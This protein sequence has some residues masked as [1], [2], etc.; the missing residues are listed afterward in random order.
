MSQVR[1]VTDSSCDLPTDV[2]EKLGIS[3]VPLKIRFGAT[4]YTDREDFTPTEFWQMCKESDE[5]PSTAAPSPGAF[6]KVFED[7]ADDGATGIVCLT[8]SAGLSATIEAAKVAKEAVSDRVDVRVIDSRSITVGLGSMAM[9][10]AESAADGADLATVSALGEDLVGRTQVWGALNTLEHLKKGGRIGAAQATLG[11][12]LSIKPIIEIRDG[13]VESPGKQRTRSRSLAYLVDI[14]RK[15]EGNIERLSVMQGDCPDLDGFLATL[16]DMYPGDIMV[17][18][19]GAVI[20][21]HGGPGT[22]GVIMQLRDGS[23]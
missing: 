18:D 4:E 23:K 5:L 7:L 13:V 21:T 15:Q 10:C 20:G 22:M 1:I 8:I 2:V 11:A 14:V 19:V 16:E 6:Q 9:Q 17:G 3:V 12:L